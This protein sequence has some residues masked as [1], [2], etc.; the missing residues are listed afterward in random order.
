MFSARPTENYAL[1][2]K[3]YGKGGLYQGVVV[4]DDDDVVGCSRM[5]IDRD[6][7]EN[8][9][10]NDEITLEEIVFPEP[11]PWIELDNGGTHF[12][13]LSA[14]IPDALNSFA[15]NILKA[16]ASI[17]IRG[18]D[19]KTGICK[20]PCMPMPVHASPLISLFQNKFLIPPGKTV[21]IQT[22]PHKQKYV[23]FLFSCYQLHQLKD[24]CKG[25]II[26]LLPEKKT[27]LMPALQEYDLRLKKMEEFQNYVL[28]E[29][30]AKSA[31]KEITAEQTME[32]FIL[33]LETFSLQYIHLLEYFLYTMLIEPFGL[34]LESILTPNERPT[35][36]QCL[37]PAKIM[38]DVVMFFKHQQ[39]SRDDQEAKNVKKGVA[40][41]D[42]KNPHPIQWAAIEQR[43]KTQ[44][45]D[46]V[47]RGYITKDT[48]YEYFCHF[49]VDGV[50][51]IKK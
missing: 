36:G 26:T 38:M 13:F 43:V 14:K 17:D 34:P 27:Q 5:Q 22:R 8:V 47:Y 44:P 40:N 25:G 23:S 39:E 28:D 48:L 20:Q 12:K 32:E 2:A 11:R 6:E 7:E 49:D 33:L 10:F 29:L 18:S 4:D 35:L 37:E 50:T 3:L 21:V 24:A 42:A 31:A 51:T 30:Y 46:Q 45:P 15:P 16:L 41:V 9:A 19:I 1:D